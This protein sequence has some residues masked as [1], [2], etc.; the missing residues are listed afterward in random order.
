MMVMLVFRV[1]KSSVRVWNKA[2]VLRDDESIVVLMVAL[3][4]NNDVHL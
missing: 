3:M 4:M 2:L 1:M